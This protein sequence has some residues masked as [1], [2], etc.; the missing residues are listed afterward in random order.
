MNFNTLLLCIPM[1]NTS[2]SKNQLQFALFSTST[3]THTKGNIQ[4]SLS[5]PTTARGCLPCPTSGK[6]PFNPITGLHLA[7]NPS[8]HAPKNMKTL[9]KILPWPSTWTVLQ[10]WSSSTPHYS[11]TKFCI[12][13][14][15]TIN[16]YYT[17]FS[18]PIELVFGY[19]IYAIFFHNVLNNYSLTYLDLT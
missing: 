13:L 8:L 15:H 10:D 1:S 9:L 12:A 7:L 6:H 5:I 4:L 16:N 14:Y 3:T 17:L 19:F 11:P 2:I 18:C